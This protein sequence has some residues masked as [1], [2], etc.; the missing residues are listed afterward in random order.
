MLT[1]EM[2]IQKIQQF[3]PEQR[4]KVIEFIE[5][6]EFQSHQAAPTP[7]QSEPDSEGAFFELA[8]IWENKDITAA[9]LRAEAWRETK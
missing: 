1:L 5:F 6:L 8:G 2:A 7:T 9:S 3:P 4:N